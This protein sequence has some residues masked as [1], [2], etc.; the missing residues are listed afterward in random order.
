MVLK[1]DI[2][3]EE[4]RS[5]VL[6]LLELPLGEGRATG[7]RV[8]EA[9]AWLL[10]HSGILFG[11]RDDDFNW[12]R[13]SAVSHVL[14]ACRHKSVF[15]MAAETDLSGIAW[16]CTQLAKIYLPVAEEIEDRLPPPEW[17]DPLLSWRALETAVV[18][19]ASEASAGLR[20]GGGASEAQECLELG[21]VLLEL[22]AH[23]ALRDGDVVVAREIW[24]GIALLEFPLGDDFDPMRVVPLA[25]FKGLAATLGEI[26]SAYTLGK[27]FHWAFAS[28]Q[29][30]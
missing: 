28:E 12:N 13:L 24:A 3:R 25:H 1:S 29:E 26:A 7:S 19:A 11:E 9:G 10:A 16:L 17:A 22:G 14:I 21:V 4:A 27:D 30:T 23:M 18:G 5:K 8:G 2:S 15:A 6:D 20:H